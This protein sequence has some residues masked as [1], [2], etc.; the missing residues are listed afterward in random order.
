MVSKSSLVLAIAV[1]LC[2]TLVEG[3]EIQILDLLCFNQFI[4]HHFVLLR[5]VKSG[6][7]TGEMI[8]FDVK[9]HRETHHVIPN[10]PLTLI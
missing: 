8:K 5:H 4:M 10:L 6:T 3:I 7:I 9:L 2:A 1:C